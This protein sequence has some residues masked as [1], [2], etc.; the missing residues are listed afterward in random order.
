M[1][2]LKL[3]QLRTNV[4]PQKPRKETTLLEDRGSRTCSARTV[5]TA[6]S[7]TAC[8]TWGTMCTWSRQS[9]T[10]SLT[11]S[12]LNA[13]GKMTLVRF[14]SCFY[15]IDQYYSTYKRL[16]C[17]FFFKDVVCLHLLFHG[18]FSTVYVVV[19]IKLAGE[20]WLYGCWFYRPNETFHLATRKFLEKEV[21]KSDYYNKAPISK[22]LGKCVVM[23]VK[24]KATVV[25]CVCL[26]VCFYIFFSKLH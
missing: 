18:F 16:I 23:F 13:C 5:R 17:D 14:H 1:W 2:I 10:S 4:N 6:A 24:V 7:K 19:H 26:F 15:E 11:S 3:L 22:I 9:P 25:F 8:T 21:F 12:T 20:K